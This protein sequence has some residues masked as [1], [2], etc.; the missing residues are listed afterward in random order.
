ME[1][2]PRVMQ[3]TTDF[4]RYTFELYR[5]EI[6]S[7]SAKTRIYINYLYFAWNKNESKL[8]PYIP[9]NSTKWAKVWGSFP[10]H[11]VQITINRLNFNSNILNENE[12]KCLYNYKKRIVFSYF[13]KISISLI[14]WQ[15][16]Y[17]RTQVRNISS[18][19]S[20]AVRTIWV[21]R[22]VEEP[23]IWTH[24]SNNQ[25]VFFPFHPSISCQ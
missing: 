8:W 15:R 25:L 17:H 4:I 3:F 18:R 22:K 16:Y 11:I 14:S 5:G 21:F 2:L 20:N 10:S 12:K 19:T 23:R 9:L 13:L 1:L 7:C 6:T 24:K